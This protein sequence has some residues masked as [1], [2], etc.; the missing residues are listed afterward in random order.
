MLLS[1]STASVNKDLHVEFYDIHFGRGGGVGTDSGN[2]ESITII[3][4]SM[5]PSYISKAYTKGTHAFDTSR[6]N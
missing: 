1:I 4:I 5:G 2:C 3:I 6:M